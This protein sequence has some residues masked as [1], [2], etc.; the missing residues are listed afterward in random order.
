M[1]KDIVGHLPNKGSIPMKWDRAI[2]IEI[3]LR[4][5]LHLKFIDCPKLPFQDLTKSFAERFHFRIIWRA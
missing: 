3:V 2:R 5:L 1:E 4:I